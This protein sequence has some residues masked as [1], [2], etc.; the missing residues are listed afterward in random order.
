ME[1]IQYLSLSFPHIYV[2]NSGSDTVSVIDITNNTVIKTIP[3]GNTPSSIFRN[4]FYSNLAYVA[5]SGSDTVSVI[6]VDTYNVTNIHVGQSPS[7]VFGSPSESDT[8]FVANTDS[9][10]VAVINSMKKEVVAG[11]AFDLVP[12]K[13][14]GHNL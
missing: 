5:N 9:N 13:S 1:I 7:L 10:G 6:D 12:F 4:S 2:A 11:I 14:E 8:V 3:V